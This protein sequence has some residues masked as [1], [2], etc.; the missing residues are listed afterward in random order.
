[1]EKYVTLLG[2]LQNMQSPLLYAFKQLTTRTRLKN[3]EEYF[4]SALASGDDED[5]LKFWNLLLYAYNDSQCLGVFVDENGNDIPNAQGNIREALVRAYAGRLDFAMYLLEGEK[6]IAWSNCRRTAKAVMDATATACFGADDQARSNRLFLNLTRFISKDST[7]LGPLKQT[8]KD[9][10]TPDV[11]LERLAKH[12]SAAMLYRDHSVERFDE[13]AKTLAMGIVRN[14]KA[15]DLR[16]PMYL[17]SLGL[18]SWSPGFHAHAVNFL[19]KGSELDAGVTE[20]LRSMKASS[21]LGP[22]ELVTVNYQTHSSIVI[23]VS[24]N[25][26]Q[27]RQVNGV[28]KSRFE[29]LKNLVDKFPFKHRTE[30]QLRY[31][32]YAVVGEEPIYQSSMDANYPK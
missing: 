3:L 11:P 26:P 13:I 14:S 28:Y 15:W 18:R 4:V 5:G 32:V 25:D 22:R 1:M 17:F 9:A 30:V 29:C 20:L 8:M 2:H 31:A 19:V 7:F 10:L 6:P 21:D 23:S 27:K 16:L 12:F 24:F